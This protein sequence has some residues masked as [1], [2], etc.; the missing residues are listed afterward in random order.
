MKI[1]GI[2]LA[3]AS[4]LVEQFGGEETDMTVE[5]IENGHSGTGFY[6]W[7]T[8]YPEDG[9]TY[10]GPASEHSYLSALP[11][12][13]TEGRK[14]MGEK[15]TR[16]Q[17]QAFIDSLFPAGEHCWLHNPTRT[18]FSALIGDVPNSRPYLENDPNQAKLCQLADLLRQIANH[19]EVSGETAQRA[20]LTEKTSG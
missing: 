15:L 16:E 7:C 4:S 5:F 3:V 14:T 12:A 1:H 13:L 19:I 18:Y 6:C 17:A 9:S 10:L 20:A 2:S 8:E 11:P